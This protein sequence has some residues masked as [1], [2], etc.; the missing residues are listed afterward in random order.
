MPRS[1]SG[2]DAKKTQAVSAP[3]HPHTADPLHKT[4]PPPSISPPTLPLFGQPA[5]PHDH[6]RRLPQQYWPESTEHHSTVHLHRFQVDRVSYAHHA[7]LCHELLRARTELVVVQVAECLIQ[8][9]HNLYVQQVLHQLAALQRHAELMC[10]KGTLDTD[11]THSVRSQRARTHTQTHTHSAISVNQTLELHAACA[12]IL[13][14]D[15]QSPS[16]HLATSALACD[17]LFR[18]TLTM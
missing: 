4:S 17:A 13:S 10:M 1:Y 11:R 6:M 12:F 8:H 18:R 7:T 3:E 9:P 16:C 5:Q 14:A 15:T 2:A